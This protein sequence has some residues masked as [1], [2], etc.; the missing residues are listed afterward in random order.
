MSLLVPPLTTRGLNTGIYSH[1]QGSHQ[2]TEKYSLFPLSSLDVAPLIPSRSKVR[3]LSWCK[4]GTQRKI[5]CFYQLK[6]TKQLFT[7]LLPFWPSTAS[8]KPP[9]YSREHT[10]SLSKL[11]FSSW[12]WWMED[13]AILTFSVYMGQD[14]AASNFQPTQ[15]CSKVRWWVM[16]FAAWPRLRRRLR[17]RFYSHKLCLSLWGG[18]EAFDQPSSP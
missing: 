15:S 4:F 9:E 11:D 13:T 7:C 6:T 14:V 16:I 2:G 5:G 10:G 1:T 18:A 3:N 17:S 12:K 8:L